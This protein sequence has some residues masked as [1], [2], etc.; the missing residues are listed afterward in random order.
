MRLENLQVTRA[1]FEE[2]ICKKLE[3]IFF[4]N[5]IKPLLQAEQ[6]KLFDINEAKSFI[7]DKM[8]PLFPGDPWK[9]IQKV[10]G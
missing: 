8:F 7:E 5:D 2:N 3:A 4:I 9:K 1:Q 10:D 6:S